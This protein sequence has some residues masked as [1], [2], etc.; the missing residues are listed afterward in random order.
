VETPIKYF[1]TQ[2]KFSTLNL[3]EKRKEF[4]LNITEVL[5]NKRVKIMSLKQIHRLSS[6]FYVQF[7]VTD[8]CNHKCF[9]CYN[10]V[11]KEINKLLT[12]KEIK[13]ILSQMREAGVF[14]VNFNGGEPLTRPDFFDFT[15]FAKELE[16]DLHLNTNATLIDD[17]SADMIAEI[18]PSIC[19]SVLSSNE[20]THDRLVGCK[21]AFRRMKVAAKRLLKRDVKI[22]VNVCTFRSN[23]K[24]LYQ[25]AEVMAQEGVHVFCVTRYIMTDAT[26]KQ[27]I[28]SVNETIEILKTLKKIK[29]DFSSYK[30]V[31]LPGPVPFCELPDHYRSILKEWNTP[32]QIGYGLCRISP[33]G[34]VTPCPLS[35]Y[36]IGNLRE[37]SFSDLWN[38][39]QWNQFESCNHL[40]A[41]C[42]DCKELETCRGGCVGYD[43]CLVANDMTP[44]TYKWSK[45]V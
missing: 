29:N 35:S 39:P 6:P 10:Q 24:D 4:I 14:S 30:E 32:C 26:C 44:S 5:K 2:F 42:R 22:E 31:K 45:G 43:D 16:F 12:T 15:T 19:L 28:L 41:A 33:F 38:H 34:I 3:K 27:H 11:P 18:F 1:I 13:N 37:F 25:I 23:Y 7:E 9:F 20:D 36:E 40:P 21:G 8:A 17:S